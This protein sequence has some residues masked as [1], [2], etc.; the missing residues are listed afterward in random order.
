[1]SLSYSGFLRV[2]WDE[3][4]FGPLDYTLQVLEQSLPELDRLNKLFAE[5]FEFCA[6]W[7]LSSIHLV[8][9]AGPRLRDLKPRR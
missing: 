4:I 1:M 5:A 8:H 6:D 7:L 9:L 3:L 2:K